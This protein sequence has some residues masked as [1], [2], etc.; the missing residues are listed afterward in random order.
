[1]TTPIN[2]QQLLFTVSLVDMPLSNTILKGKKYVLVCSLRLKWI[3]ASILFDRSIAAVFV[4]MVTRHCMIETPLY[5]MQ[6]GDEWLKVKA[7]HG[8]LRVRGTPFLHRKVGK[9]WFFTKIQKSQNW[10]NISHREILAYHWKSVIWAHGFFLHT[11]SHMS[12]WLQHPTGFGRLWP[13]S[14]AS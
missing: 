12:A 4:A 3:W 13:T 9:G 2:H 6:D 1:M 11:R 7:L 10:Q 8:R 14:L 5:A